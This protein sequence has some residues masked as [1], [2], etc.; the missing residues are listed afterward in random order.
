MSFQHIEEEIGECVN[1]NLEPDFKEKVMA[2]DCP[3]TKDKAD[4]RKRFRVRHGENFAKEL[5]KTFEML[6]EEKHLSLN[7]LAAKCEVSRSTI[8]SFENGVYFP[9]WTNLDRMCRALDINFLELNFKTIDRFRAQLSDGEV[10]MVESLV[11][12]QKAALKKGDEI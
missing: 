4:R 12:L 1:P 9:S 7:Q 8:S 2:T 5:G 10:R 11:S 3:P 6:R